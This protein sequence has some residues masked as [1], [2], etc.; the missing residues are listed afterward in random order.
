MH[1]AEVAALMADRPQLP[2]PSPAS[3]DPD[4]HVLV[5]IVKQMAK[6][7][8]RAQDDLGHGRTT[9]EERVDEGERKAGSLK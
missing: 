7:L 5:E 2:S 8:D 1:D 4:H 3:P 9:W 6:E